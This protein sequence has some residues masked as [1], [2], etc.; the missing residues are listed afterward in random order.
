MTTRELCASISRRIAS[1]EAPSTRTI[2]LTL[3]ARTWSRTCCNSGRSS[4]RSNCLTAP[5]RVEVPAARMIADVRE[6][7]FVI[8]L[9]EILR[10][11][12]RLQRVKFDCHPD[13]IGVR[14]IAVP[15]IAEASV[16]GHR[17]KWVVGISRGHENV[18]E[19]GVRCLVPKLLH[20]PGS[21]NLRVHFQKLVSGVNSAISLFGR[22]PEIQL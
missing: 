21:E 1:A 9:L 11:E 7:R 15:R 5:I 22:V 6:P 8:G 10:A 19:K 3:E 2:S 12:G 18:F 14:V 17:E 13:A 16:F 20:V 4:S